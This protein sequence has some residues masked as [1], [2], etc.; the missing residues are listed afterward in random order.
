MCM[1]GIETAKLKYELEKLTNP[2][3]MEKEQRQSLVS[4]RT[5]TRHL[6]HQTSTN[7]WDALCTFIYTAVRSLDHAHAGVVDLRQSG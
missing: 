1:N 7:K 2:S 5:R 3:I 4:N 6:L